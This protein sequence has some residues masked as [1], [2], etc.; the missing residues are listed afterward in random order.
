MPTPKPSCPSAGPSSSPALLEPRFASPAFA[1]FRFAC[2]PFLGSR[3]ASL[4]L[5]ASRFLTTALRA[6]RRLR[7][8]LRAALFCS[9]GFSASAWLRFRLASP[10]AC[11][12]LPL[13][14]AWQRRVLGFRLFL[15]ITPLALRR[16]VG[17]EASLPPFLPLPL[18]PARQ[19]RAFVACGAALQCRVLGFRLAS[20][21]LAFLSRLSLCSPFASLLCLFRLGLPSRR[22]YASASPPGVFTP[23]FSYVRRC[24]AA[25]F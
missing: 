4:R 23:G 21:P 25:P 5:S 10:L 9:A 15:V 14:P 6:V 2:L 19:C 3:F 16:G 22:F 1:C 20:L 8:L 11:L 18:F 17:G 7:L 24:F 13:F 12:P